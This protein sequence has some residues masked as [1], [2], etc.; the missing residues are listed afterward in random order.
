MTIS[1]KFNNYYLKKNVLAINKCNF[2]YFKNNEIFEII[3]ILLPIF[4][5]FIKN[6]PLI[7]MLEKYDNIVNDYLL[8]IL[9]IQF[10][11][12]INDY[13]KDNIL[14]D[15][16]NIIYY[17]KKLFNC[18]VVPIRSYP[19]TFKKIKPN[20]KK[21]NNTLEYLKNV[22][23]PP[24]RTPEWY[25]F[26]HNTLTASN[27]WKVFKTEHTRNQLIFEKCE[28]IKEFNKPSINSP[29]HWGQKYEPVSIMY[30]EKNYKTIVSDFGCIQHKKYNFLA[31]SP[32]GINTLETSNLYG[33]M[34]EIKN[35]VNREIT[36]IP[37]FEYWIQMQ[38]QM[39][40]CELNECDFL[41]TKFVEYLNIEE[42]N[43]DG[44]F[45]RSFD[46]KYKGIILVFQNINEDLYYEYMPLDLTYL[47]Y[48]NWKE[49][50]INNNKELSFI[51]DIY[52]KLEISSCVLVLRN[53]YWFNQALPIIENFWKI[54]TTEKETG[55][56][57]RAPKKRSKPN[58]VCMI[59]QSLLS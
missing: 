13:T 8:N 36:G 1:K 15:F 20:F 45:N 42:F 59:D 57:H 24:Q 50:K 35:I 2:Y 49:N 27:I 55:Y 22:Y 23:Q 47:E 51:K 58:A 7:F 54:I 53:K 33:R 38:L 19:S 32:D 34:L 17:S 6:N 52:W 37:K 4:Y 25:N 3:E 11:I 29:L 10:N 30:Y 48:L 41:E 21:L 12:L 14:L 40:V 31:A 46:N 5:N 26:R 44:S 9:S 28:P 18:Y 56:Q 43:Q 39:E 16:N